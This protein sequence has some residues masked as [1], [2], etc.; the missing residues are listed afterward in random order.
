MADP[1]LQSNGTLKNLLG[2]S[3]AQQLQLLETQL[4]RTRIQELEQVRSPTGNFDLAHLKAIHGRI[5]GDIYEWAGVTRGERTTIEGTTFQPAPL[6]TKEGVPFLPANQIEARLNQTFGRLAD[7]QVLRGLSREDFAY[8]AADLFGEINTAHAFRE[9]NGRTQREFISQ[10]ARQAEHTLDFSVVS[11]ERMVLASIAGRNGDPEPLR[12]LFDEISD[13]E[14][15]EML[16]GAITTLEGAKVDWNSTYLS[17][18]VDGR[19]YTG[20]VAARGETVI[21]G[22]EGEIVVARTR[23]VGPVALGD[24]VTFTAGQSRERGLDF[25]V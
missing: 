19:D 14:R 5:F 11:Q 22:S 4:S 8:R 7:E 21:L 12:R 3:D 24:K 6:L 9:G 10:L 25:D 16:R 20:E 15:V 17:T 2:V 1:Y 23:D 13:P 18:T